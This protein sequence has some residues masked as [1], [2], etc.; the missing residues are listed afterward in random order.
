MCRA[1]IH[2]GAT[3]VKSNIFGLSYILSSGIYKSG[4]LRDSIFQ[5]QHLAQPKWI[6]N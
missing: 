4:E 6:W 5:A 3:N 2:M 1:H